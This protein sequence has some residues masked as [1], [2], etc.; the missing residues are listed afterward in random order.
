MLPITLDAHVTL[1]PLG[2]TD[3]PAFHRVI[4]ANRAHLDRWLR[5]S[6]GV[7]TLPDA[8][9]FLA[10]FAERE[11]RGDGF[12]LG[13]LLD[14]VL[15]GG[16]VCWY[17]QRQNRNAEV[18]YWLDGGVT[19]RGLA[20]R[21]TAAVIRHL[22]GQEGLQRIEMQC[23]VENHASRAIPERL[24]FQLEGVRRASH[25]ITDRFVDHA[26]YGLLA[27]DAGADRLAASGGAA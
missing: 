12:H 7:Q 9:A 20:T 27:T 19:G 14:G 2:P 13:I 15:V 17:I 4:L 22:L 3:A 11:A 10:G 26:I 21:A 25:W 16:C 1:R 6:S 8:A 23:G 24:G 18:G 5:W